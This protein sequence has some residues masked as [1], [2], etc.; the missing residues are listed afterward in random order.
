VFKAQRNDVVRRQ[1]PPDPL[2]LEL[3]DRLDLHGILDLHQHARAN[4]NLTGLGLVAKPRGDVRHRANGGVVEPSL[5]ADGAE[6]S[7]TV[8]YADAEANL[9]PPATPRLGQRS[10]GLAHFQGHEDGL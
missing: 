5:E 8:R 6:R 7:E 2:Q 4:E 3:T 10:D 1:R 9:V